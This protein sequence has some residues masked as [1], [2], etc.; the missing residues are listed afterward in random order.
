MFRIKCTI[1]VFFFFSHLAKISSSPH[2]WSSFS[3][4]ENSEKQTEQQHK[5]KKPF[6]LESHL[7]RVSLAGV[8]AAHCLQ[9]HPHT[10]GQLLG[11]SW[12]LFPR[13]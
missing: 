4:T 3:L 10:T 6:L 7:S 13:S 8:L 11:A 1:F 12:L 2:F 5:K 9:L